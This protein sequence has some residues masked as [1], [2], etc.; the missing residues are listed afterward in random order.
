MI[1][2]L[3]PIVDGR[4]IEYALG[5]NWRLS[6]HPVD[7]L[8]DVLR[9]ISQEC[10]KYGVE[11]MTHDDRTKFLARRLEPEQIRVLARGLLVKF[12]MELIESLDPYQLLQSLVS[13]VGWEEITKALPFDPQ[14]DG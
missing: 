5:M 14:V 11:V 3:R 6:C 13:V 8:A 1:D 7:F 2:R 9:Q 12:N 10:R 4:F